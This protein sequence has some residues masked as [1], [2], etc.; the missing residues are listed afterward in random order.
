MSQKYEIEIEAKSKQAQK[1][2]DRLN[3]TLEEQR[4]I[5]IDLEKELQEIERIQKKTSKT[6]LAAQKS[7][8]KQAD[9][10]KDSIKDQR[11][12]LRELSLEQSKATD[13]AKGL[14]AENIE[15]SSTIALLDQ[16][17]G[18][19]AG[20]IQ[21]AYEALGEMS[22]NIKNVTMAQIRMNAAMLLNPVVL[23]TAG[24]VGLTAAFSKYLS[25]MTDGVVSTTE[26]FF[27][28]LKSMGNHFKFATLMGE[29]YEKNLGKIKDAQ[30]EL[31]LEK[32]IAVLG[33][34]GQQTIDQ[35]I[36]LAELKLKKL[37]EGEEGYEEALTS[38]LV[39]RAKKSKEAGEAEAKAYIDSRNKRLADLQLQW[40]LETEAA[41][42][43]RQF[44]EMWGKESG[45]T[46]AE[47]FAKAK[48]PEEFDPESVAVMDEYDPDLDP[49]L[50]ASLDR[51]KRIIDIE[52]E[53]EEKIKESRK[54]LL[55]NL[56]YIVGAE[57]KVGKGLLIAKQVL[58]AKELAMELKKTIT[59]ATLKS[60]EA[61]VA[62]TVG[63][64]K[65]L[66]IGFPQNIPMLIGYAAQAAGIISSIKSALSQA[67]VPSQ[68]L[69][70]GIEGGRGALPPAFNIVGAAPENQLAQ[71]I[72]QQESKPLKA[73][74][75]SNEITNAQALE[76]NIIEDASIG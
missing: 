13:T 7:L 12:A 23:I 56:I 8:T 14:N 40:Q 1:E 48:E 35:E 72:G 53:K 51:N 73:F 19:W 21:N 5:L 58:A 27:N 43:N 24:V 36:Q 45:E 67:K 4:E 66:A 49:E 30:D 20:N 6:N 26:T 32:S 25:V 69:G 42:F 34:Y 22:K 61:T 47:A 52:K 57:S 63:A 64:A 46:F 75:V 2:L 44:Y 18:G 59:F 3:D 68:N 37:K 41:E 28:L 16:F 39:L 17:T 70:G 33:A 31:Q 65:T 55:D 60:S 29:T 50:Q 11:L 74:V 9:H 15:S 62:T 54:N 10:L 76:R 71:A 38:L